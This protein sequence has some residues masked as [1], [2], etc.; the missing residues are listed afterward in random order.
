VIALHPDDREEIIADGLAIGDA[1]DLCVS[2]IEA[3]RAA[4][5]TAC[6]P[7][8]PAQIKKHGGRQL[9]FKF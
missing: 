5:A 2:K 6:Q 4:P 1:E 8:V 3:R 7:R 9:A